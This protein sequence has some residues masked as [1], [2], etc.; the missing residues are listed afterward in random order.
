VQKILREEK[1]MDALCEGIVRG[2]EH[3]TKTHDIAITVLTEL[4]KAGFHII[5]KPTRKGLN[6]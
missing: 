5:P 6:K 3:W 2:R 4:Q 1:I